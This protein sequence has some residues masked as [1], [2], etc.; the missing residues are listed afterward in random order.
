MKLKETLTLVVVSLLVVS[1]F[2]VAVGNIGSGEQNVASDLETNDDRVDFGTFE[3]GADELDLDIAMEEG[4]TARWV[5]FGDGEELETIETNDVEFYWGGHGDFD[6]REFRVEIEEYGDVLRIDW[7]GDDLTGEIPPELGNLQNLEWLV[8]NDNDLSGEIP[9]ELGELTNLEVI[10]LHSNALSGEIPAELGELTNLKSLLLAMNVLSGEIPA[11]LGDLENLTRLN[12]NY[13]TLSGY[14]EGAFSTQPNLEVL[15]LSNNDLSTEGV[16]NV[17][18]DLVDS[19]YLEDRVATEVDLIH[20]SAP[21]DEGMN[22]KQ[23]LEVE[24]WELS[25]YDGPEEYHLIFVVENKV[26]DAIEGAT[27][28]VNQL[29]I[30]ETNNEDGEAL[31]MSMEPD[32]YEYKV[33]HDDYETV[34]GDVEI[35]D[36]DVLEKVEMEEVEVFELLINIEGKGTL[37]VDDEEVEDGWTGTYDND[38]YVNLKTISDDG[39]EFV[40]WTGTDETGEEL[41]ITMHEDKELTAHFEIKTYSPEIDIE[42]EGSVE[43]DPEQDEYEYGEE[44]ELTSEPEEGWEFDHWVINGEVYEEENIEFEMYE[45]ID[46]TVHFEEED[47]I[48]SPLMI[49]AIVIAVAI[50]GVI[51]AVMM[52]KGGEG[53]V[54]DEFSEEEMFEEEI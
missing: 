16:D 33:T 9:P 24:G 32:T 51:V 28:Q 11:E 38:T 25:L 49:A 31:F 8:L 3:Y 10:R 22:D 4:K 30:E 42:G 20:N 46:I 43:I 18:S 27:L 37:E 15:Q 26:G 40:E 2:G 23:I 52:K 6:T 29:A 19:L 13:N 14:G 54:E 41:T 44:I 45:D 48:L 53:P 1:G 17:L 47:E 21:S 7:R 12:L 5:F 35:V 50:I 39:W 34:E 36:E